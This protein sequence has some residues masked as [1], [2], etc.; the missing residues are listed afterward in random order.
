MKHEEMALISQ[1]LPE[2]AKL[3]VQPARRGRACIWYGLLLLPAGKQKGRVIEATDTSP[4]LVVDNIL[5][6]Y[7]HRFMREEEKLDGK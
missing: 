6:Q 3:I 7:R 4:G 5:E 2:Q 1:H